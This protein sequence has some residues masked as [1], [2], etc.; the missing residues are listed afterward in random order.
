[1]LHIALDARL[2]E[3][4]LQGGSARFV[5]QLMGHL[6]GEPGLRVS[7]L[8]NDPSEP[9]LPR[10]SDRVSLVPVRSRFLSLTEQVELPLVLARVKPDLFHSPTF[11][12]LRWSPCPMALTIYDVNHLAFPLY[13]PRHKILF[14]R[15][16]LRPA[17]RRAHRIMTT[18]EFSASEIV[19]HLGIP[20]ERITVIPLGVDPIFTE[21]DVP[22]GFRSRARLPERFFL[23]VGNRKPHKNL[24]LLMRAHGEAGTGW[25][26]V[27]AGESD[28]GRFEAFEAEAEK[29]GVRLLDD[30][31]D[32]DLLSLY[33]SASAFVF[34]SRYEGF[35]LP[36]L[37]AMAC[38]LPVICSKAASLPEAVGD[39]A[40]LVPPNDVSAWAAAM[41]KVARNDCLREDLARRGRKRAAGFPWSRCL[42]RT[43]AWYRAG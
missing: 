5:R 14:Y 6:A 35:G 18:S 22:S 43:V 20:R 16:V 8:V 3:P 27:I 33:G 37:E 12:A 40:V 7:L 28:G 2:T 32:E 41:S 10:S 31:S 13:Y 36:P 1:M 9:S 11:M 38:G 17:A 21:I 42:E 4:K 25:P 30:L 15:K 26:L 39:A 19:K 34:P 23:Y 24:N 29:R